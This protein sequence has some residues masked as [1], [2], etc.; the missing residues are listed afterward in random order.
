MDTSSR[1]VTLDF[2]VHYMFLGLK[3]L[4]VQHR[5]NKFTRLTIKIYGQGI[6]NTYDKQCLTTTE[7]SY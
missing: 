1:V 2:P 6:I 3:T 4:A 5:P 7:D